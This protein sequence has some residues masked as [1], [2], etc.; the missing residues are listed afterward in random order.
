MLK[1][2]ALGVYFVLGKLLSGPLKGTVP[3]VVAEWLPLVLLIGSMGFM[4]H[5]QNKA[6]AKRNAALIGQQ[7]PDFKIVLKDKTTTLLEL[8]KESGIPTVVDFYQNF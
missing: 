3:P 1:F 6:T 8:I 7:A 4:Q 5:T 2:W